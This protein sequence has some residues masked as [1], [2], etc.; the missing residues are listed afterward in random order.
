MI[1]KDNKVSSSP[2]TFHN[3]KTLKTGFE[4]ES[5]PFGPGALVVVGI[6]IFG[7]LGIGWFAWLKK[8]EDSLGDFYLAGRN[9][10]LVVLF[11]TMFVRFFLK[12]VFFG[13]G[14]SS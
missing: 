4:I 1:I 6:Y 2:S 12:S 13:G 3:L 7:M 11:L 8:K 9:M 5:L 14:S 10:G